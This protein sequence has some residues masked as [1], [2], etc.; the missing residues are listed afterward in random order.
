MWTT[1]PS[2]PLELHDDPQVLANG[3][4][5]DVDVGN[6]VSLPLVTSPVQF[7]ERPG[8]PARAPGHSCSF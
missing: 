8:R 4:I 7:D 6:G 1:T 3:Y 5:A 2:N